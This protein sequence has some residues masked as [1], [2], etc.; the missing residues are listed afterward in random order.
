MDVVLYAVAAAI[1]IL[2]IVFA[3]KVRGQ[4]EQGQ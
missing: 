4:A 1:L 2:L 3:V